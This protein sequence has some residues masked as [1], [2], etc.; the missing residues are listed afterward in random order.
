M[1]KS[2]RRYVSFGVAVAAA[3]A[4]GLAPTSGATAAGDRAR[5]QAG[6][7]TPY[8]YRAN[9]FG[10]KVVVNGVELKTV[11]D[12]QALQK[13]TRQLR[14]EIVK[15]SSL[16]TD[17]LL[18]IGNDLIKISP[19]TSRTQTY[20][21][22]DRY[23]V[24]GI[25]LIADI[26][27]GGKIGDI[28]T[29]VLKIE[30]LQSTADSYVDAGGNRGA[31]RY[32]F[33]SD[34]AFKGISLEIPT[35]TALPPELQQLLQIINQAAT[36]INQVVNQVVQLLTQVGGTIE[37]PGLGS[38][39]LG[40][41]HGRATAHSAKSSAYALK[42]QVNNPADGSKTVI[43]L[44]RATSRISDPVPVG[45]VPDHDD[46]AERQRRRPAVVRRRRGDV[47]PLRGHP[48]QGPDQEDRRGLRARDREPVRRA[49]HVVRQA[50]HARARRA[51][52]QPRQGLRPGPDRS[53]L[54]AERRPGHQRPHLARR[55][56]SRRENAPV[57]S[58]AAT[59]VGSITLNGA[60]IAPLQ[61]GRDA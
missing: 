13:C 9:T 59:S 24:R 41:R 30:G 50:V 3:L 43:Q 19:S 51:Q 31:D 7:I 47:H 8:A 29:P 20:H 16:G 25:N 38:L 45:R 40:S 54:R 49:V 61:A 2:W 55:H 11:K 52:A 5:G 12:A 15:G 60:A 37:I 34:F 58:T 48:G 39:G 26:A 6:G 23:G 21:S 42:I 10:T 28:Q 22:G 14:G 1:R 18:P 32:G 33:G 46:R 57:H 35:G 44:G 53:G 4:G 56:G 17:G 27:V 36:P